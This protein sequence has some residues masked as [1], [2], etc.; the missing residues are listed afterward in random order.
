M[1]NK[2]A[3]MVQFS[4]SYKSVSFVKFSDKKYMFASIQKVVITVI[5][6][7]GLSRGFSVRILLFG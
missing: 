1:W 5:F 7:T 4:K 3:R 6:L 2:T